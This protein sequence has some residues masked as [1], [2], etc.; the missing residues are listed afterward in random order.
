MEDRC[1]VLFERRKVARHADEKDDWR[2]SDDDSEVGRRPGRSD[3]Y[4]RPRVRGEL[5]HPSDAADGRER[6]I[7]DTDAMLASHERMAKLMQ[8]HASKDEDDQNEGEDDGGDTDP[9]ADSAP[10]DQHPQ[11]H[12]GERRM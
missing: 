1:G 12:E 3:Q 2:K 5:L 10:I 9:G 6:N 4:L 11:E 8:E 7:M